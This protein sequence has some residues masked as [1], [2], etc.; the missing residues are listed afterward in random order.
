MEELDLPLGQKFRDFFGPH[1]KNF[2]QGFPPSQ[3]KRK[4]KTS[5]W[6][7]KRWK[8]FILNSN[9]FVLVHNSGDVHVGKT[10]A[11]EVLVN[12]RDHFPKHYIMVRATS[13]LAQ[14][15]ALVREVIT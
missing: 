8:F 11:V 10:A 3:K 14:R 13:A 15:T 4:K 12:G 9:D 7:I 6:A 5:G 2:F 1:T